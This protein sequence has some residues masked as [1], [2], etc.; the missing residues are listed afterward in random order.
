MS[1]TLPSTKAER[2]GDRETS[3]H[4]EVRRFLEGLAGCTPLVRVESIGASGRGQDIPAVIVSPGKVFTPEA[5]DRKK[6]L[7]LLVIAN[8]HAGEVEG[9]EACLMLARDLTCGPKGPPAWLKKCVLVIVP[10]YN[11]DGN[12]LIDVRNRVL[13]LKV[14]DGQVGPPGGVGT[15]YTGEG[16]NLNRDYMKQEAVESVALSKFFGRWRPH[17]AVDCHTTNGSIHGYHLTYDTSHTL[18][19]GPRAPILFVRDRFLPELTRRL[20]RRTG[21][22]TF[23]YGNYVDQED[24]SKGWAT[25][26]PMPRYG[27][28]YRGLTGRMDV[29]LECY[30]YIPFD[31][32][33]KV[34]YE[35]LLDLFHLAGDRAAEI[36]RIVEEAERD[37]VARGRDPRPDD[38]VGIDYG[39]ARPAEEGRVEMSY[40]PHPFPKPVEIVGWDPETLRKRRIEGGR[41]R[42]YRGPHYA[43]FFPT[44]SVRRPFA[45]VVPEGAV[46]RL[47]NHNVRVDRL[48]AE[49][50][51]AV[52]RSLIL[53]A[54]PTSS[55]DV[56]T[57]TL[58]ETVYWVRREEVVRRLAPGTRIVALDQP[59]AAVAIYLLEPESDDGLAR[60]NL[61][62]GPFKAGDEFPVLRIPRKVSLKFQ[63]R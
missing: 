17:L 37:V 54:R 13:D 33:I 19:S 44:R 57:H 1:T 28:H 41:L 7:K 24:P 32:R 53:E 47:E 45:Y 21:Y 20:L 59:P 55:P 58:T 56:G 15:R 23:F 22:R 39:V 27:S 34:M 12:D 4:A 51:I 25:Y 35:T 18:E 14:L 46:A 63:H 50:E 6:L 48:A 40:P 29:L 61:M 31:L 10:N 36:R 8:I 3:T 49:A 38:L 5:A 16:V 60:W 52:E 43:L 2:T 62:G 9:K 30:S 11:P 26:S 42:R